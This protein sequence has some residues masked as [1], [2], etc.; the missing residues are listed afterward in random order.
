MAY[1]SSTYTSAQ[2]VGYV[3]RCSRCGNLI[4]QNVFVEGKEAVFNKYSRGAQANAQQKSE[5]NS[6]LATQEA[7]DAAVRGDYSKLKID[8]RCPVCKN[9][10][11]WQQCATSSQTSR[12]LVPLNTFLGFAL[13]FFAVTVGNEETRKLSIGALIV[14]LCLLAIDLYF[15][16]RNKKMSKLTDTVPEASRPHIFMN[17]EQ[18][19]SACAQLGLRPDE[20]IRYDYKKWYRDS[21][22]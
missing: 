11:P 14:A 17:D 12:R 4:A 20:E 18:F 13:F 8:N 15:I 19:Q 1:I 21:N 7:I 5:T 22:G 6:Q 2:S 10:E 9:R 3:Y 16:F